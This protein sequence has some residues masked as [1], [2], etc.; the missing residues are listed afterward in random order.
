MRRAANSIVLNI[1]EGSNRK[2]DVDFRRFLYHSL[3]SLED[4]V[5]C[6]DI[7]LDEKY[8]DDDTHRDF[9]NKSAILGKQLIAFINKLT[10]QSLKLTAQGS[11]LIIMK[12]EVEKFIKEI[13]PQLRMDGGDVELIDV[14]EKKGV[15]KVR[16]QGACATCP[17]STITLKQG[18]EA[19]MKKKIKGVKEVVA[20]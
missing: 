15:V 1:A 2:N 18:I 13:R 17:M 6:L 3:T 11:K 16:L 14:D 8:I 20:V 9:L 10:A 7:A 5:A 19:E 4:V 12:K